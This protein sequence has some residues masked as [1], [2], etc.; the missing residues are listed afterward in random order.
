VNVSRAPEDAPLADLLDKLENP[1]AV[2]LAELITAANGEIA[3]WLL[4][5]RNRRALPHRLERCGYIS[6]RNPHA[7]D[8]L[9]K[10]KGARQ[11]IYARAI[12]EP[13]EREAA[14]QRLYQSGQ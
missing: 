9:W 14:A 4:D 3:E 11:V 6:V 12:L 5:R 10:L 7:K 13:R 8:G 2:T 1:D